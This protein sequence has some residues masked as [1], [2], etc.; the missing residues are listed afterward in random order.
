MVEYLEVGAIIKP[1]GVS[2][3]IKVFPVAEADDFKHFTSL[4][5]EQNG[6]LSRREI[7]GVKFFKGIVI[8]SLSG[9]D[10]MNAAEALRKCRLLIEKGES[11]PTEPDEYRYCDLLDMN[12]FT[13][14][15]EE[16]GTLDSIIETGA[17]D[18]YSVK[19]QSG[20]EL[21][22]PAI[23]QCILDVDTENKKMT[24]HLLEGLR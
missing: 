15:G 20:G 22:I 17:N 14:E 13:D 7:R 4:Y 12:V 10:D 16:L 3:E 18:V 5:V 9:I 8:L 6:V 11:V 1:H 19:M 21:L 23:K 2:G 24:V